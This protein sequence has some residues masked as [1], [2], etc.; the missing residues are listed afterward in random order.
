MIDEA[1]K[2]YAALCRGEDA[3]ASLA[4]LRRAAKDAE[5][6]RV[7]LE[8]GVDP[9]LIEGFLSDGDPKTRKNAALLLGELA[10]PGSVRP[11]YE[12]YSEEGTRFARG[13]YLAALQSFDVSDYLDGLQARYDMLLAYD[14]PPEEAKH[15]AEE[16]GQLQLLLSRSGRIARHTFNG[17]HRP[18]DVIFT[19]ERTLREQLQRQLMAAGIA[20]SAIHPFGVRAR[21]RDLAG[22][23]AVR[24]Y[25]EILYV[26][27]MDPPGREPGQMAESLC[28]SDLIPILEQNHADPA[29]FY[30]RIE[31]RG[32][33]DMAERG[34]L[35]KQLAREIER[36]SGGRLINSAAG[37][38]VELRLTK[39]RDGSFYPCL[40]LYTM[41]DS[42]FAWRKR[43]ISAS[44]HPSLA[45]ALIELASPLLSEDA[46]VLDALCG[47]GTFII[48]RNLRMFTL[49]D[50][51]VDIYGEA[52]DA[53]RENAAA[54]G[55]ACNFI[56]KD[57]TEFTSRHQMNEIFAD[58]PQRGKKTKEEHDGFYRDCFR[59]FDELLA[60]G[61][62]LF[63]YSDETG[64]VKKYLR[65]HP[66]LRL[67]GE[68]EIKPREGF[69]FF[70][71]EKKA[72]AIE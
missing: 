61:G 16:R 13:A 28:A 1:K 34:K 51:A 55:V 54:A 41:E 70:V 72:G 37:Y 69:S 10:D 21:T 12:A 42:R 64:F 25:R 14:A 63:L 17:W 30:F 35:A 49:D 67:K 38:E 9:R 19:T 59:R 50:Y 40:K 57:F 65:L 46:V 68:H 60:P 20:R 2:Y 62:H 52:V 36:E 18:C 15:V 5:G 27:H 26:L 48:E 39:V 7:L 44:M 43:T 45:A 71:V 23:A 29:P 56:H 6:Q 22:P 8:L 47:A 66:S 24:T 58:M 3:R 53:A 31:L 4:G 32:I 11:L 33:P